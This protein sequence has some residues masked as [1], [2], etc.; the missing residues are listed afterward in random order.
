MAT[1][2]TY[3]VSAPKFATA[4]GNQSTSRAP[5]CGRLHAHQPSPPPKISVFNHKT[6]EDVPFV[7]SIIS[8]RKPVSFS[9][10]FAISVPYFVRHHIPHTLYSYQRST[11]VESHF[12]WMNLPKVTFFSASYWPKS[13]DAA[14]FVFCFHVVRNAKDLGNAEIRFSLLRIFHVSL[15][16]PT[17]DKRQKQTYYLAFTPTQR[18][19][20]F[21]NT[22]ASYTPVPPCVL[23]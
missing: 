20:R 9:T 12:R 1:E 15:N 18:P 17:E 4:T 6:L 7:L 22:I 19:A 5:S 3:P 16:M 13:S 11:C 23:L 14:I 10:F 8:C 2:E 21:T